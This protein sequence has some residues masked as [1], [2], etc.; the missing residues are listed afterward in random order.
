MSD[1]LSFVFT[2]ATI[3]SVTSQTT[4]PDP[5]NSGLTDV[6]LM[7]TSEMVT[8]LR[9]LNFAEV[10]GGNVSVA[11]SLANGNLA[12]QFPCFNSSLLYDPDLSV[13]LNTNTSGSGS[14]DLQLLA[15]LSLLIIPLALVLVAVMVVVV[16]ILMRR[17]INQEHSIN[18]TPKDA[19]EL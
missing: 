6:V 3:P 4:H 17:K 1:T 2:L 12:L 19:V 9:L 11:F 18:Y 14:D 5:A 16:G 7:S 13:V 15:L 8:L 10:D